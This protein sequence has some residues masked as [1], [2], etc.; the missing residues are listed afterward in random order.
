MKLY[1]SVRKVELILRTTALLIGL[2]AAAGISTIQRVEAGANV[3]LWD[4]SSPFSDT[5]N[6]EDRTGWKPVPSDLLTLEADPPKASSDPG[7]YGR[8]YTFKGDAVVE[9]HSLAAVFWSAKGRVA[10]YSKENPT[11]PTG[12]SRR[13]EPFSRK[14][15]EFVPLQTKARQSSISRCEILRNANDEVALQ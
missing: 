7:Y 5:L 13:N 11:L 3:V 9:N 12:A 2:T 14:I 1:R 8:E 6:V 4:T 15:V 10:I